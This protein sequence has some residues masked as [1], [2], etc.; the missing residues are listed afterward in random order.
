MAFPFLTTR[1]M[2]C[3]PSSTSL[4]YTVTTDSAH[5]TDCDFRITVY[6]DAGKTVQVGQNSNGSSMGLVQ[7][8]L[9]AEVGSLTAGTTY[10][11][12]A[13]YDEVKGAGSWVEIEDIPSVNTAGDEV[14][15]DWTSDP[16][17]DEA[18]IDADGDELARYD[19]VATQIR[20]DEPDLWFCGGDEFI[21]AFANDAGATTWATKRRNHFGATH[22]IAPAIMALGNHEAIDRAGGTVDVR[23][24][25]AMNGFFI[26]PVADDALG[27][28]GKS[29]LGPATVVWA[30]S[31]S[32][33]GFPNFG[34]NVYDAN[35]SAT[36]L[37]FVTDTIAACATNWL[38]LHTHEALVDRLYRVGGEDVL[39]AGSQ[40]NTIHAAILAWKAAGAGRNAI[41]V[42]GHD[43]LFGMDLIDGIAY[44]Q[45]GSPCTFFSFLSTPATAVANGYWEDE[46][47]TLPSSTKHLGNY[48]GYVRMRL[49]A[50]AGQIDFI[51]TTTAVDGATADNTLMYAF[52]MPGVGNHGEHWAGVSG[53]SS[54]H[55]K[56][57]CWNHR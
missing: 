37:T 20:A 29:V 24:Q 2:R 56:G 11:I 41:V 57:V 35:L 26:N 42:R 13:E 14:I 51:R 19:N 18:D 54:T 4:S 27:Y 5:A 12:K 3:L 45:V 23:N 34:G 32:E 33:S 17:L 16:H 39:Q 30:E 49:S 52:T 50:H 9:G 21:T 28:Y 38:I 8:R 44:V 6:S 46:D 53:T 31:F 10:Y 40:A 43:H 36:Q 15:L 55:W 47:G 25:I 1:P 48:P 22:E 7:E